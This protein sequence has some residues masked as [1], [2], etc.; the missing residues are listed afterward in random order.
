MTPAPQLAQGGYPRVSPAP[1]LPAEQPAIEPV[2]AAGETPHSN[3]ALRT[4]TLAPSHTLT[5]SGSSTAHSAPPAV[6]LPYSYSEPAPY[7]PGRTRRVLPAAKHV[8]GVPETQQ[9]STR[10][11]Y[12]VR[13]SPVLGRGPVE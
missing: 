7:V 10:T 5:S 12:S 6:P 13:V 2:L 3:A 4:S 11:R 1:P 8:Q 9:P